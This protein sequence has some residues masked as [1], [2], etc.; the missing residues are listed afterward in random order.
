MNGL[1]LWDKTCRD[2]KMIQHTSKINTTFPVRS[3]MSVLTEKVKK[4][5]ARERKSWEGNK[6]R[7]ILN[8]LKTLEIMELYFKKVLIQVYH[9]I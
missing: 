7:F 6:E 5:R 3:F 1:R 8:G 2:I 4:E 9:T